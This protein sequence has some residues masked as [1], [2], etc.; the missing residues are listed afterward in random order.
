MSKKILFLALSAFSLMLGS[1][2]IS[3]AASQAGIAVI[4]N[5]EAISHYDISD[6]LKLII[7]SSGLPDTADT[8]KKIRPQIIS[9]LID[10]NIQIQE[11]EKLGI[12][13]T[14]PQIDKA[15]AELAQSN[16][17]S[18]EKFKTVL[19]QK[20]VSVDTLRQQIKAKIAWAEVFKNSLSRRVRISDTDVQAHIESLNHNVGTTEYLLSEIYLPVDKTSQESGIKQLAYKVVSDLK[21]RKT[22]FANVARQLSKSAGAE[23]GGALGWVQETQ[24]EERIRP[25]LKQ[26]KPKTLSKPLRSSS[27]Y[28]IYYLS[29]IRTLTSDNIP[30]AEQIKNQLFMTRAERVS[31]NRLTSLR[32]SAYID[33]RTETQK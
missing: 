29:N 9:N 12:T 14:Q 33:D 1:A 3:H 7:T 15:F 16:K 11:A 20:N 5:E 2:N 10:E 22:S 21:K 19:G 28:H 30:S 25:A 26:M 4:V 18:A 32:N 17:M 6:R 8:H 27:G 31:A 23:R 13:I 24:I